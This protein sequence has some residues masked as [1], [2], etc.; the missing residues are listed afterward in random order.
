M[1]GRTAARLGAGLTG[2]AVG[3]GVESGRL[4]AWKPA[5]GGRLVAAVTAS[6]EVQLATVRPGV[7]SLRAP[8]L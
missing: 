8:R 3:L 1:A 7:L 6:S 2:D 4:V 5:F